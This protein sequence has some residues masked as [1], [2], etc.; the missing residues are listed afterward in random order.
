M[1]KPLDE[2]LEHDDKIE[3]MQERRADRID[4][5]AEELDDFDFE[6]DCGAAP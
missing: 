6:R 4:Q 1:Y 2:E 3:A 5:L